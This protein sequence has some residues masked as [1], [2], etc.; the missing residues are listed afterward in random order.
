MSKGITDTSPGYQN[1]I[2]QW[3]KVRDCLEGEDRIK[4]RGKLYLPK[5]RGMK[6]VDFLNYTQRAVFYGVA[7]R[8]LRG[9]TGLVFRV[10]PVLE[11]P[12]RFGASRI[13]KASPEGFDLQQLIRE[14]L[15]ENLSLGRY[16]L[17]VDMPLGETNEEPFFATWKGEDI[18]HWEETV[19]SK[20]M[21]VLTRVVVREEPNTTEDTTETRL[22]DLFLNASGQYQ[23]Q[24][25]IEVE[26]ESTGR[27]RTRA[28]RNDSMDFLSGSFEKDGA[29]ITPMRSNKPLEKVPFF[30]I[31]PFDMRPR[32][33]KPPMLDLANIN[34]AHYRN[35][36]D[37]ETAL[38]MIG[39]PTPYV[40]G[41]RNEDK[42]TTVGPFQLW[43]GQAREVKVGMLE[44]NGTGVSSIERAMTKKEDQMAVLGARLI[45]PDGT[46]RENV[47]AET[48]RLEA[49]EETSVLLAAA[50]TVEKAFQRAAEFA[51][52]WTGVSGD[53]VVRLNRDF[54]E[55]RL[56]PEE[57]KQ[58]VATWQAEAISDETL[59][60][61]LQRGEI[62]A[63]DRN[64]EEERKAIVIQ[65]AERQVI[66]LQ[67]QEEQMRVQ[68]KAT[69][70]A[71]EKSGAPKDG[72]E[73]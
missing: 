49:R 39:S 36:A 29:V 18:F 13:E 11:L 34:L 41:I 26:P 21:R 7:D 27:S 44:Y 71:Q 10:D 22:R 58:L 35:S 72:G 38:H 2:M 6:P 51:Q 62:V 63:A 64:L 43:H 1:R 68:A 4:E 20:G 12:G 30:F 23:V 54:V 70:A 24:R 37:H 28:A 55:T 9:L 14:A 16:G 32:T 8:T 25:W 69:A 33:D 50:K 47:T 53:V 3:Q 57:L 31:N 73:E 48:T 15:R 45:R 60:A 46:D 19:D 52:E 40:F 66:A 61:N 42:P 17:L 56:A 5:P 65:A 59:H 67:R